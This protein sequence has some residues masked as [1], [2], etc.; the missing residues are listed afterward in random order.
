MLLMGKRTAKV[1]FFGL[2]RSGKSTILRMV[3]GKKFP[4]DRDFHATIDYETLK[5]LINDEI[6]VTIFDCG[7]A[8]PFLDRFT[9][10]LA[11]FLF[12]ELTTFVFVVDSID[13]QGIHRAKF[14]LDLSLKKIE[15]YS[16]N[17]HIFL[18]QHKVDLVPQ[19]LQEEVH[20][21]VKE[22]LLKDI[23][24]DIHYYETTI[25]QN[26][27][28]DAMR[29]VLETTV[30]TPLKRYFSLSEVRSLVEKVPGKKPADTIARVIKLNK[31]VP[32]L[33]PTEFIEILKPD[34]M[35][36]FTR[37]KK[38]KRWAV[39]ILTPTCGSWITRTIPTKSP[40]V[41]KVSIEWSQIEPET[42]QE[43]GEVFMRNKIK[44]LYSTS[45]CMCGRIPPHPY[46]GYIDCDFDSDLMISQ[47]QLKD[48]LAEIKGAHKVEIISIV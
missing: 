41:I 20:Q 33:I 18:F 2:A 38:L 28:D 14:Y 10:E 23:A 42:F 34:E 13:I 24:R 31:K 48:E 30:D 32:I 1:I 27:I 3:E 39:M 43:F 26:G 29:A 47:E 8:T 40:M 17:A 7:G 4:E 9:G 21:T 12:S 16:P 22:Y 6:E 5:F 11:E 15:Q 45:L 36:K 19:K 25:I 37:L 44:T 35:R 46:E